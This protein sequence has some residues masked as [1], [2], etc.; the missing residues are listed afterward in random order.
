MKFNFMKPSVIMLGCA[1]LAGPAFAV[2]TEPKRKPQ[3]VPA[4]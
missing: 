1:L 2:E 4:V 3:E